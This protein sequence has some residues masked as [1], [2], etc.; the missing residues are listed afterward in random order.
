MESQRIAL[1]FDDVRL[2][3]C[4]S[5]VLPASVN[6]SSRFSRNVPLKI[7]VVSSPMDT[8]TEHAMAIGMAKLGGLGIIH[9]NLD[10][11]DQVAEVRKVK[12]HL[13]GLIEDPVT[14]FA[15]VSL[16]EVLAMRDQHKYSFHSFPVVDREGRLVGILTQDHF[17]FDGALR[18]DAL[19]S[20][21]MT[22]EPL[23][24]VPETTLE[25][26]YRWM[27]QVRKKMLPLVDA[28]RYVK[29]LYVWGDV[30]RMQSGR[31]D[32][33]N[34]DAKGRLR[35]GAAVGV[36]ND[37]F[38]R[39]AALLSEGVDVVVVDTAHGDSKGVI[40]TV[41]ALK[42]QYT[43]LDV[44]AGNVSQ[45]SS[46]KHLLDAG[47]DGIK[48]GQGPGSICTTRIVAGVGCPQVSAVY[49]CVQAVGNNVPVCAD[50]GLRFSGDVAIALATGATSV[51]MGSMLAGT[52]ESP[53]E[54]IFYDGRQRKAYRGMGSLGAMRAHR[55]SADRYLQGGS[56]SDKFVPEGVEGLVDYRGEL[57]SVLHQYMGG[58]RASMGYLGAA[59][60]EML[61]EHA[62]FDYL[63]GAGMQESHPHDIQITHEAPNYPGG[64]R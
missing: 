56:G 34:V 29:G 27:V 15:D 50:G 12:R 17:D 5:E 8:V 52:K 28:D 41:R 7:P 31:S 44:V 51:M 9:K 30:V 11:V 21:V 55:A 24:A 59:N 4:Y 46:A 49:R 10:V 43:S 16:Q 36:Y 45:G 48:V 62:D 13:H 19:V 42:D 63:T 22:K 20:D 2:K 60:V 26:A 38:T 33:F 18:A 32:L 6:L 25:D 54:L 39:V 40:E 47:A 64:G 58:L 3:T 53:G 23:V 37:A 1:T 57:S 35:V 61:Q 14:V